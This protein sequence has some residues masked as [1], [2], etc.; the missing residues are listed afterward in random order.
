MPARLRAHSIAAIDPARA[1]CEAAGEALD[2]APR[3][4]PLRLVVA[5]WGA[6]PGLRP[7]PWVLD[8]IARAIGSTTLSASAVH[9][10]EYGVADPVTAL[11]SASGIP[12]AEPGATLA[13][14]SGGA[15]RP[16]RI[17]RDWL[18]DSLCLVVPCVHHQLPDPK[19]PAWRGP[20]GSALVELVAGWGGTWTRDPVDRAARCIAESFGHVSV[21][22]DGSW[23]AP[24]RAAD[25][26][27]PMLLA[28]ERALGLRLASP[29]TADDAVDPSA[30]DR[31]LGLQLGLPLRR[32]SGDSP[33]IDGPAAQLPWPKLSRAHAPAR[34]AARS[35]T[36]L[37]GQAIGALWHRSD[38]SGSRRTALPPAVPGSLAALWDEY[39]RGAAPP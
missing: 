31:W 39:Q 8:G 2:D 27:A 6:H 32:R 13:I 4:R 19:G 12:T 38:R 20:I 18:G 23:W 36:G 11:L 37:A 1:A 33:T 26:G 24:L 21:I 16:L 7:S 10:G 34:P 15:R 5:R 30:A 22:L 14:R 3:G 28:P 25:E 9:L 35:R 29:I 17:P